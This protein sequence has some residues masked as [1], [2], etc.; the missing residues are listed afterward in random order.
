MKER[1]IGADVGQLKIASLEHIHGQPQVIDVLKVQLRAYFNIRSTCGRTDVCFGPT[2]LTGPSGTGKTLVAKALHA[3]LGNPQLVETNGVTANSKRELYSILINADENTTVFI[4]EAQA[5]N[6]NTQHLLLTALSERRGAHPYRLIIVAFLH[7][8]SC[9]RY[10]DSGHPH[11]YLLQNALRNR[12]RTYCR[13][14]YYAVENLVAI[15]R[16]RAEA[17]GWRY[18]SDE[19]LKMIAQ[20]AKR[21]P[22]LALHRNLQTCWNVA[23]SHDRDVI[24]AADAA[25]AFY[26]LQVDEL[27]LDQLDRSYLQILLEH[28]RTPLAVLSSKLALPALTVQRII[29]P[30]LLREDFIGKDTCSAR[31]ITPKG[32]EHMVRVKQAA[33]SSTLCRR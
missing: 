1:L 18:E 5:M 29:E 21:T 20:R 24:T 19:V 26:H 16:Q 27:G 25:E 33:L 14:E 4:D 11:E 12:M 32:R 2:L 7:A 10:D 31:T 13:F 22:R 17:L 23:R 28:G 3:E 9:H 6:S 8:A 30:Y 15:V